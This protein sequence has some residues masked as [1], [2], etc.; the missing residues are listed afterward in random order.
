MKMTTQHIKLWERGK[1]AEL[2]WKFIAIN[3]LEKEQ[4][5]M[6]KL[7]MQFKGIELQVQTKIRKKKN[8]NKSC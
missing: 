7:A 5:H 2:R 3:L 8:K 4:S 1:K 6:N